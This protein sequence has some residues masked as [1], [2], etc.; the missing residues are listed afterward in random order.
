MDVAPVYLG[1]CGSLDQLLQLV[2][3][4]K[5]GKDLFAGHCL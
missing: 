4:G 3:D 2:E 1:E 5:T